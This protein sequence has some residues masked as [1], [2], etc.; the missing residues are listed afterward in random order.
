FFHPTM[1][2]KQSPF[3]PVRRVITGHISTGKSTVLAD[4]IQPSRLMTLDTPISKGVWVDE[5]TSH[6]E[7]FSGTGSHFRCW[8]FAPGTVTSVHRT[9]TL[10]YA[11]VFKG[12]IT[13]ELEEGEK[14]VL[15]EGD[16]VIQRGTMHTWRNETKEWAKLYAIMS[17]ASPSETLMFCCR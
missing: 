9:I 17:G 6:P 5:I 13:L 14:I 8:D 4:T 11:V 16:T 12:S 7:V 3:P 15:N 1:S 2:S 10:D